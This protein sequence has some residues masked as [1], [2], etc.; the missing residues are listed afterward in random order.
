MTER[1]RAER[2]DADDPL[3]GFRERFVIED[4]ETIYLDGNSL[5]RL[6]L[7]TRE[8][9]NALLDQWGTELVRGWDE[10]I[11]L[12]QRVGDLIGA[13]VLGAQPGETLVSDSTTV[14]LFK[15]AGALLAENQ[16]QIVGDAGDFPTNRYVLDGL[17]ELYGRSLQRTRDGLADVLTSGEE[18]AL[19]CLSH[20][21]YRTG[22]L[23]D[24]ELVE[25]LS[26]APVIWDLSH[27]AGVAQPKGIRYA[28]GA[29]YKYLNGGPGAPGFLYVREDSLSPHVSPIQG[30]FGHE[31]QFE[32]GDH[33]E[34]ARGLRRFL[35]GTPN[36]P[37][38]MAIEEGVRVVAE[39]GIDRLRA[40][41]EALTSYAAELHDAW[42][43][44]L[45][46]E[47]WSPRD[48]ARRG[49]HVSVRHELA[50]PICRALIER[51]NVIPDFRE[52]DLIR[53]GFAPL[54]TRF[55]DVHEALDRL[56]ALVERGDYDASTPRSRVT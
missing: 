15:L 44:P 12:P 24:T 4:H 54:Y 19:V 38:L 53:L 3:A 35:T 13:A 29:T 27:S 1:A 22:E 7:A 5:G 8:R 43:A 21:D 45:G 28:V 52:P 2:L 36:V 37:A 25:A 39:A 11:E 6:P 26:P 32:M 34:P 56:R 10:W 47:L 46:F 42:L 41:A 33:Y 16:G 50:W 18:I 9:T 23:L 51:A 17:M 48:P 49:A 20:V 40:K 14:N 55:V 30:W 31:Q